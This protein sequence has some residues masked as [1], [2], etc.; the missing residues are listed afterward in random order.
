MS[1]GGSITLE[2]LETDPYPWYARLRRGE[3]V[4]WVPVAR[5]VFVTRWADVVRVIG[6][7][8]VFSAELAGSPLS[9]T[10]GRN[11]LHSDGDYHAA[12]RAPLAAALRPSRVRKTMAGLVGELAGELAGG[13]RKRG[14]ADLVG[15]FAERLSV[16]ALCEITGLPPLP[17]ETMRGWF[18]AIAVGAANFDRDAGK[19]AVADAASGE[20]DDL[21]SAQLR[22]GAPPDSLLAALPGVEVEGR[23]LTGAEISATVKLLI[24]GGMQEPRDLIGQAMY[25]YCTDSRV[26]AAVADGSATEAHLVEEALRWGSPVGTA[27][28]RV[29]EP[30]EIGGTEL[31]PGTVVAAVLASA[32]RDEARWVDPD[33]FDPLR[34]DLRH[35]AF[36]GGFHACVGAPLARLEA[37]TAVAALLRMAPD[38]ELAGDGAAHGWEFRGRAALPV[39]WPPTTLVRRQRKPVAATRAM[40]V[41]ERT[42]ECA[43]VLGLRLVPADGAALP[44]WAPGAHIDVHT[45]AGVRQYSLCGD[46][47]DA[48]GWRIAVLDNGKGVS[49]WLHASLRVGDHLEIT[50]PRNHLGLGDAPAYLFVAGGIGITPIRAMVAAADARG[51]PW[52]LLY[53]GRESG[54]PFADEL[55]AYG[56][57]ARVWLTGE[58]GRPDL[59]EELVTADGTAVYCC[60]PPSLVSAVEA[61]AAA[62]GLPPVRVERFALPGGAENVLRAGERSFDVVL[63]ESGRRLRVGADET[64]LQALERAEVLVPS[65]CRQGTCGS[66]ETAVLDG[67]PDHRDS[68]LSHEERAA[69]EVLM[70][71]V[72]RA[73]TPALVLDL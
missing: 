19:Q 69:G 6:D 14:E 1:L 21:V 59:H 49:A 39:R 26:R 10:I 54:M 47:E 72:S 45:P 51:V 60:G 46:P 30:V 53:V 52:Q 58:R 55:R 2:D 7:D 9:M 70:V 16:G 11:L 27:T 73:R 31:A 8:R 28:R 62:R 24:V 37:T 65:T 44:E 17:A 61:F 25:A 32:N 35:L 5:A 40:V 56:E 15:E 29:T 36:G 38:M 41:A 57:H 12:V 4:C 22:R 64:V 18:T 42:S 50:G 34:Q 43:T 13:L 3:P 20:I 66:C 48:G 33:R 71:C 63:H 67:E 23:K 68:V